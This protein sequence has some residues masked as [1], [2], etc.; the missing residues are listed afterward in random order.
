M[1]VKGHVS[2]Y[3]EYERDLSALKKVIKLLMTF[4]REVDEIHFHVNNTVF[5]DH[6][7][8]RIHDWIEVRGRERGRVAERE[9][10]RV[11]GN[12]RKN[13]G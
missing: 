9:R 13:V 10:E 11:G 2:V 8:E 4:N 7:Y 12:G 6:V 3:I 1:A 5:L